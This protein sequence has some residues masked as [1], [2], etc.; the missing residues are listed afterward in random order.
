M[1]CASSWKF[2]GLTKI[3]HYCLDER[4]TIGVKP[5]IFIPRGEK[6]RNQSQNM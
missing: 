4:D 2:L 5:D 1:L 3:E 6:K